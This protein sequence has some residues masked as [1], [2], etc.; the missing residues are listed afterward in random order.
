MRICDVVEELSVDN[1]MPTDDQLGQ[2]TDCFDDSQWAKSTE[3]FLRGI[4][5]HHEVP[6]KITNT[7]AGIGDFYREN[8]MLTRS[9]K[10]WLLA[11]QIRYWKNLGIEM[12][13]TL[14]L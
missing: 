9:Q 14:M 5:S 12:R 7:F 3:I 1:V 8:Q 13:A 10:I 4:G 11:H 6:G 2:L